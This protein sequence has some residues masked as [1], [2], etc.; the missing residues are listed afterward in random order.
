MVSRIFR[1]AGKPPASKQTASEPGTIEP[2]SSV[3]G[4]GLISQIKSLCR[5]RCTAQ[6]LCSDLSHMKSFQTPGTEE[7]DYFGVIMSCK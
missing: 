1:R 3:S 7:E 4:P 5:G 6:K 2:A